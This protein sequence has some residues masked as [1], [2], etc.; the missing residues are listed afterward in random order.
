MNTKLLLQY[1]ILSESDKKYRC[2]IPKHCPECGIKNKAKFTCNVDYV[3]CPCM[4]DGSKCVTRL[5]RDDD[6]SNGRHSTGCGELI[7]AEISHQAKA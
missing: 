3:D 4:K 5:N 6:Y 2:N 7:Y 1:N